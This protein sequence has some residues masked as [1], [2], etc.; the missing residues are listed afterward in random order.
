MKTSS[1]S[2]LSIL[3]LAYACTFTQKIKSGSEA[4]EVKQYAVAVQMLQQ[5]YRVADRNTDRAQKA[6]M[7][8]QSYEF[9]RQPEQASTWYKQAYELGFGV[10]A[11]ERQADMLR[12]TEDYAGASQIYQELM[13]MGTDVQRYRGLVTLCGQAAQWKQDEASNVY[14]IQAA[15]FN[16][17]GS[18][19][20]P[21]ILGPNRLLFTSDRSN[22]T[23][24]HLYNWSG[25]DFSDLYTVD[26]V[27]GIVQPFDHVLNTSDNEGTVA[28][29]SD[30]SEMY[31]T[32]CFPAGNYDSNCKL[33]M[34]RLRGAGWSDP[35]LLP[36]MREGVNYGHP[37]LAGRDS[38]LIFSADD[39]TGSGGYDLY[40]TLR[41]PGGWGE[42]V[43][44]SERINTIG[45]ERFPSMHK[46]TL[47]FSSDGH[48]GLGGYDIFKTYTDASG[49]WAP[50]LNL[51]APINSGW[52]DF[53]F[54]VDTFSKPQ[55]NILA[56]GY[57]SS[58]RNTQSGDDI[59]TWQR[60]VPAQSPETEIVT[61]KPGAPPRYHVYLAIKV[62]EP[63]FSTPGDP[64]S[65]RIGKQPIP[66]VVLHITEGIAMRREVTDKNGLLIFELAWDRSYEF[67]AIKKGY[68]NQYRVFS[69]T[70]L[71]KD[72]A[73]PVT[74]YNMEIVLER[75]F[76]NTEIVLHDI[77]YDYDEWVIREDAR[78]S[79]DALAKILKENP[80]LKIQLSSH[81]DCRGE[82]DYNQDL[83]QKRA[84]SAVD[85]LISQQIKTE[86]MVAVGYG[87]SNFAVDCNC[88]DCT[89]EQHQKNRRTTFKILTTK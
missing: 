82:D 84:Q 49:Q 73:N 18:D 58:S 85:Y 74:T 53:G 7:I 2:V 52:D 11:R 44:F 32:R 78:P 87:E 26:L 35:E 54:V 39:P 12:Q 64:N 21:Y 38:I 41:G 14:K 83:S 89:E 65:D 34:C 17:P 81:T 77:Y 66:E 69:T 28:M 33:M 19:Y 56:R 13:A 76:E 36:F 71:K 72:P 55:D 22:S 79:L 9:M 62:V 20:A 5:E 68:L 27:S 23:G 43:A 70:G 25:R 45:N 51:K 29:T 61:P 16:S 50:P 59:Y 37:A 47:Y 46:D 60:Q 3:A 8:G 15:T 30:L 1:F 10:F 6:F 48:P 88:G 31:F 63:V 80:Q 4:F 40:Y 75:I 42:P 57:F 67:Q 24:N 86:R